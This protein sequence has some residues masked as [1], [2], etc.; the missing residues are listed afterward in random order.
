MDVKSIDG[1]AVQHFVKIRKPSVF[2]RALLYNGLVSTGKFLSLHNIKNKFPFAKKYFFL[3]INILHA[4]V[5][6]GALLF[7]LCAGY[8]L[9]KKF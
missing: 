7:A 1:Y 4:A 5:D 9:A 8:F 3:F 2:C 6:N